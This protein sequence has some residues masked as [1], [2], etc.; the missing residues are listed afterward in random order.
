M[1]E[2]VETKFRIVQMAYLGGESMR[3]TLFIQSDE[4]NDPHI[5][6]LILAIDL[7]EG[8]YESYQ[9]TQTF[10]MK[11]LMEFFNNPLFKLHYLGV[12]S[13]YEEERIYILNGKFTFPFDLGLLEELSSEEKQGYRDETYMKWKDSVL[14]SLKYPEWHK[15]C[16]SIKE[17]C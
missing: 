9:S 8:M 1:T 5:N 13:A 6:K 16:E 2:T 14:K 15:V 3:N 11:E 17:I 10:T 7:L 4:L 12:P